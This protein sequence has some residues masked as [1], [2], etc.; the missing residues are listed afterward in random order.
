MRARSTDRRRPIALIAT[1]AL[2]GCATD[3]MRPE[4]ATEEAV[5]RFT[6]AFEHMRNR[7][8]DDA[9]ALLLELRS[10]SPDDAVVY[11][12]LG[13]VYA[14]TKRLD[15][16][17][18]AL[19]RAIELSP[20]NAI[21]WNELGITHRRAGRFVEAEQAYLKAIELK[22]DYAFAHYNLG[23]LLDLYLQRREQAL[24]HYEE[25]LAL[26]NPEDKKVQAWVKDLQRR[27]GQGP[28]TAAAGPEVER[29]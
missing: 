13:I 3:G 12:N 22:P 2:A 1:L 16:S 4:P 25:Y 29:R 17:V 18:A 28:S 24:V 23:V 19:S 15:E 10:Q 20:T 6:P 5:T 27:T 14:H 26:D 21:A 7:E 9:E 11:T 8:F